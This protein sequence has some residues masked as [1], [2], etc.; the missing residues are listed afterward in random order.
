VVARTAVI[1]TGV[2]QVLKEALNTV[3]RQRIKGNLT[4]TTRHISG[5]EDEEKPQSIAVRLNRGWPQT[6]T[7][8]QFVG[9]E[10]MKEGAQRWRCHDGTSRSSGAAQRSNR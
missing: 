2:F 6:F 1:V 8:R 4:E 3:E 7:Q 9:E 5:D 10:R